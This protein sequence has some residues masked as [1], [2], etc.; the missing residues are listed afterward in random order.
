[1]PFAFC[2]REKFPW[3]QFAESV[4]NGPTTT[5]LKEVHKK[6]KKNFEVLIKFYL[7]LQAI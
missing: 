4:D 3:C 6:T 1:M 7:A 2:T 5:F